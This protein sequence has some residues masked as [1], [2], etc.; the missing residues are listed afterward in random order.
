MWVPRT[1]AIPLPIDIILCKK[2]KKTLISRFRISRFEVRTQYFRFM[3]KYFKI[4]V[5]CNRSV[6]KPSQDKYQGT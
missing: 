6:N 2:K 4:H 5:K 1:R 3:L